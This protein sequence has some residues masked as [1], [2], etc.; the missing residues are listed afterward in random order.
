LIIVDGGIQQINAAKEI[1]S[2]LDLKIPIAGLV[3]DG[4]HKTNHL[5]DQDLNQIEIDKKS[6]VF[7]LITRVQDEAHRFA[8]TFHKQIR[9]KGVFNSILDEVEG[10]GTKT[11]EK[12]LNKYKSVNLIKL[13]TVSDLQELGINK[14]TAENL[15][16]KLAEM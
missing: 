15:M 8:V 7:H 14:K 11:K 6:D 4:K 16:N 13:A 1:I 10:I 3:K 5:L 12:L 2:S 9:N